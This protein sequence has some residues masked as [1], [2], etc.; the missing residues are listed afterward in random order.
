MMQST[1]QQKVPTVMI[2]SLISHG[3]VG[4]WSDGWGSFEVPH[5]GGVVQWECRWGL[6]SASS[7]LMPAVLSELS[8]LVFY[9]LLKSAF[10]YLCHHHHD[11]PRPSSSLPSLVLL[12]G[13][14]HPVALEQEGI[15]E[16]HL[17]ASVGEGM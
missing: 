8:L 16:G 9:L 12:L 2:P 3:A 7:K 5:G 6:S 15:L 4:R 11:S 1:E 13:V 10:P 17:R 14:Q